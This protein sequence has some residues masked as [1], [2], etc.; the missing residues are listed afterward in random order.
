MKTIQV[1]TWVDIL[2]WT[3]CL[4]VLARLSD[5]PL[6]S[7][8]PHNALQLLRVEIP[9]QC[10]APC[11]SSP[12]KTYHN[13]CSQK[14]TLKGILSSWKKIYNVRV[15]HRLG[16][17]DMTRFSWLA[18]VNFLLLAEKC[19]GFYSQTTHVKSMALF[20]LS[21]LNNSEVFN[22]PSPGRPKPQNKKMWYY[23]SRRK[24]HCSCA[25]KEVV[26]I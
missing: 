17:T 19:N 15:I 12:R 3:P 2:N 13:H 11:L 9:L 25:A 22:Y 8:P 6:T 14:C 20:L 26:C 7:S 18:I 1:E 10:T 5:C 4:P 23:A 21:K 24:I 16:I